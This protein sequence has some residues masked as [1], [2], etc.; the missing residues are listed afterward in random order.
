MPGKHRDNSTRLNIERNLGTSGRYAP[1]DDYSLYRRD[2]DR[3]GAGRNGRVFVDEALE[4][5]VDKAGMVHQRRPALRL[6][7][8]YFGKGPKGYKRSDDRIRDEV[9]EAL[10]LSREINASEIEIEVTDGL[11]FLRGKVES[12]PIKRLT[13]E[14]IENIA[15]V[16][17]VRNELTF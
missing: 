15:G 3:L 11:V 5:E 4:R 10:Y 17:D 7:E 13:E 16:I 9:N 8:D 12:R 1:N 6:Q 2:L 14:V